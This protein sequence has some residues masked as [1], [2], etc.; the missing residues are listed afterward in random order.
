MKKRER[1]RFWKGTSLL[2]LSSVL[3]LGTIEG[4]RVQ[5]AEQQEEKILTEQEA[6]EFAK[7]WMPIPAGYEYGNGYYIEPY[8]GLRIPYGAW[9][10]SWR[11]PDHSS[12]IYKIQ[13]VTGQLLGYYYHPN[14]YQSTGPATTKKKEIALEGALEFLTKVISPE[15]RAKL[16]A[17]ERGM[18][19]SGGP[20]TYDFSFQRVENG[21]P[22]RKNW[23]D[24]SAREDGKILK[25]NL[26]WSEGEVPD[27]SQIISEKEARE[28]LEQKTQ[29]TMHYKSVSIGEYESK[30]MLVY[31]YLPTDSQ[32]VDAISGEMIDSEGAVAKPRPPIKRL[33][34]MPP[35]PAPKEGRGIDG[36]FTREQA[37]ASAIHFLQTTNRDQ[38]A[39]I[40]MIDPQPYDGEARDGKANY[41]DYK[42][43][44]GWLKNGILIRDSGFYVAVNP[45]TGE[46]SVGK[47]NELHPP[48]IVDNNT[49]IVDLA[50]AR[51]TEQAAN[52]S[53]ELY[54][55]QP[56]K[57]ISEVE[58]PKPRLV[59]RLTGEYGIVD[60]HTG[61]WLHYQ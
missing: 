27:A 54:Y 6:I 57:D 4:T 55:F 49:Q 2:L 46:S 45:Q 32:L 24:L 53:L 28:L 59:Y 38:L 51:R 37:E 13:P 30:Y 40:Y 18:Y 16:T 25:F 5:A 8:G 12:I 9:N 11:H 1:K 47:K 26:V 19:K 3:V 17:P 39:D 48:E 29:P 23:I 41:W 58:E 33:K 36:V 61:E 14:Y 52:Q 10:L 44:F 43:H 56:K 31:D 15:D 7:K 50:F 42:V 35:V 20:E 22:F 21:I 34:E 60:A